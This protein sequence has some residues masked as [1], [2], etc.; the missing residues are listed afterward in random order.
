MVAAW[1]SLTQAISVFLF[2]YPVARLL[3]S[4]LP[5]GPGGI[6]VVSDSGKAKGMHLTSESALYKQS[7]IQSFLSS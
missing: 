4:K 3:S 1:S 2:Y 6:P 5:F 7:P